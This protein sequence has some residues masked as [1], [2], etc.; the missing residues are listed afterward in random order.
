MDRRQAISF[1]FVQNIVKLTKFRD[2]DGFFGVIC[3]LKRR[4]RG[5][6][7]SADGR[8]DRMEMVAGKHVVSLS[9]KAWRARRV[10]QAKSYIE[11]F[12]W[13]AV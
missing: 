12:L 4:L 3:K 2:F 10:E 6:R 11:S 9:R 13:R 8:A 5:G 1:G 7:G